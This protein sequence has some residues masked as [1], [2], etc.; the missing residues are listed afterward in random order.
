[1]YIVYVSVSVPV[2]KASVN[3]HQ[4]YYG[5]QSISSHC[6]ISR[7][8]PTENQSIYPTS[9]DIL[10]IETSCSTISIINMSDSDMFLC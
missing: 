4:C 1:M 6:C 5:V 2:F 10:I 9:P 8:V 7:L 3:W